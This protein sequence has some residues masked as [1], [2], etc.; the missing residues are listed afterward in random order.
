[1]QDRTIFEKSLSD[2][3]DLLTLS[4]LQAV[5]G[6]VCDKTV[7]DI[8]R[9]GEIKY[10]KDGTQYCLLLARCFQCHAIT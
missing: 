1:M 6:G 9:R 10:F 3:P 7:R 4:D 8:V 2:Y 5:L